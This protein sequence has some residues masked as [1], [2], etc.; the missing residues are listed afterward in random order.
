MHTSLYNKEKFKWIKINDK[1]TNYIIS[2]YGYVL[3]LQDNKDP[4]ILKHYVHKKH[5]YLK[6]SIDGIAKRFQIHRLV[7]K[8]FIPNPDELPI[9]HHI[10]KN[11]LNNNVENLVWVS[12]KEHKLLHKDELD[13]N[14]PEPK[15]G[16]EC[17]FSVYTE[18]QIHHVCKLL[19]G[20]QK[21]M[22]EIA[23]ETGVKK[24]TVSRIRNKKQWLT[25]STKYSI[26]K[27]SINAKQIKK[28]V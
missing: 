28:I 5:A 22:N 3:S 9:V 18:E 6:L 21:T 2:S 12:E 27:Y 19:E 23:K 1:Q 10:D 20:N 13:K 11:P 14:R 25:I 17:N 24:A 4:I 26:D 16:V 7:A 8:Y 15:H